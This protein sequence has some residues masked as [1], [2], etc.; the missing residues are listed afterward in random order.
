MDGD[1]NKWIQ[2]GK[3]LVKEVPQFP[4][5]NYKVKKETII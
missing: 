1:R 2:E 5:T 4:K 3:P